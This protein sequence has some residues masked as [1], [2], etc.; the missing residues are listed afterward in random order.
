MDAERSLACRWRSHFTFSSEISAI[1]VR[2]QFNVA[3]DFLVGRVLCRACWPL[4]SANLCIGQAAFLSSLD[5]RFGSPGGG[6]RA[7]VNA[8]GG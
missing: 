3:D 2:M 4:A 5:P 6:A 1:A 7:R 8:E